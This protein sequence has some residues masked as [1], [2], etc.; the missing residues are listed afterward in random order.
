MNSL[1][2]IVVTQICEAITI[3]SPKGEVY[4]TDCRPHYGISFCLEGKITYTQNGEQYISDRNHAIILP[5]GQKYSLHR[6]EKGEFAVINFECINFSTDRFIVIPINNADTLM[7]DFEQIKNLFLFKKNRAKIMSLFYSIIHK[8]ASENEVTSSVLK[9][10]IKYLETNL[11]S[12]LLSNEVLARECNISEVYFRK[13][14]I[15]NYGISPR[16]YIIN[17][18][19]EK[20]KQLLADGILKINEVAEQCGFTNPYH[21][22]RLFKERTGMTCTEYMRNN[23]INMI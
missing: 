8:I 5:K 4:K 17:T 10:A 16:Q 12:P 2:N 14:F 18:R 22:C 7:K 13:L 1:D 21:F 6:D 3:P 9:P 11:S 15:K 23:K 20:A 19:I